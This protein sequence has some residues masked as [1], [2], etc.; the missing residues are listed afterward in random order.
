MYAR[1]GSFGNEI[2]SHG[3]IDPSALYHERMKIPAWQVAPTVAYAT[4][5][6]HTIKDGT[7]SCETVPAGPCGRCRAPGFKC[8]GERTVQL[9][10][11]V[12]KWI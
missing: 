4:E 6:R 5:D 12:F 3:C 10:T 2:E 11:G 8:S 9:A 7:V 1:Q